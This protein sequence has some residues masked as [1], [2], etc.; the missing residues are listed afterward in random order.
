MDFRWYERDNFTCLITTARVSENPHR[1]YARESA[2]QIMQM[3]AAEQKRQAK[4]AQYA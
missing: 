1:L 4:I 2:T 3:I